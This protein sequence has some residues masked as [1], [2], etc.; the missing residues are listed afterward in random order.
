[1]EKSESDKSKSGDKKPRKKQGSSSEQD[2]ILSR[3]LE[4]KVGQ[5]S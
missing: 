4:N 1:M 3:T 5:E 2:E